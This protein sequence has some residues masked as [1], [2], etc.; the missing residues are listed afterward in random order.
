MK[1]LI[2]FL[3]VLLT[4]LPALALAG[5]IEVP[6]EIPV[7]GNL[8]LTN[9]GFAAANEDSY[10]SDVYGYILQKD[11]EQDAKGKVPLFFFT[12][13]NR[14]NEDR[15][16]SLYI[17]GG[18]KYNWYWTKKTIVRAHDTYT[19]FGKGYDDLTLCAGRWS[20]SVNYKDVVAY[21][22]AVE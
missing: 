8:Y 12:L 6:A 13:E 20:V 19:F 18:K 7:R 4:F 17:R 16:V 22:M 21:T 1:R 2:L 9:Y 15:E 11:E 10:L 14:G 5:E 3:V